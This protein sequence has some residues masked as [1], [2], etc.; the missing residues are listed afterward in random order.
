VVLLLLL[1]LGP[2]V[3]CRDAPR[4]RGWDELGQDR[5]AAHLGFGFCCEALIFCFW[6]WVGTSSVVALVVFTMSGC[7]ACV[8]GKSGGGA[9]K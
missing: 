3:A 6:C 2:E 8:V 7:F 1:G 5:A 9:L 4:R